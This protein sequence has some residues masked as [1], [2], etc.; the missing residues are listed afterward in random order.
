MMIIVL[1]IIVIGGMFIGLFGPTE[2]AGIGAMCS[3]LIAACQKE[4]YLVDFQRNHF[5]NGP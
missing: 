1:F 2:A 5:E 4:A 3:T